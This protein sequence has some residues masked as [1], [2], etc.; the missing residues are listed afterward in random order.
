MKVKSKIIFLVICWFFVF[1]WCIQG[2]SKEEFSRLA[3]YGMKYMR[4]IFKT[5]MLF[6]QSKG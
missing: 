2:E 1:P 4:L 3:S 6:F 5:K